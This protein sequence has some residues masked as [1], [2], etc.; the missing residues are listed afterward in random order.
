M[1]PDGSNPRR[2]TDGYQHKGADH[3]RWFRLGAVTAAGTNLIDRTELLRTVE[4]PEDQ[5]PTK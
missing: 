2:L 4:G 3:F 5:P 1:N